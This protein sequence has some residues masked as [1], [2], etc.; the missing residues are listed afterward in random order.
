[1]Q[2]EIHVDEIARNLVDETHNIHL[3][4]LNTYF[5]KVA[6]EYTTGYKNYVAEMYNGLDS[7]AL[8]VMADILALEKKNE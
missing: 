7:N 3:C 5:D 8:C 2:I 1:M 4:F 6:K